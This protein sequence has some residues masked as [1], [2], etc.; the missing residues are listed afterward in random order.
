MECLQ[1]I[2][3]YQR[4][5]ETPYTHFV[6]VII[7]QLSHVQL[8]V[9]PWTVARQAPLLSIISWN[10][11]KFTST[12]AVM[13]S[14]S[15]S[16][17]L[18]SFCLQFFPACTNYPDLTNVNILPYM[19]QISFPLKYLIVQLWLDALHAL[20]FFKYSKRT[21][22]SQTSGFLDFFGGGRGVEL[23][24]LWEPSSLTRDSNQALSHKSAE[25]YPLNS[26]GIP[27]GFFLIH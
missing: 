18:F 12:E 26:Q 23:C 5:Q 2:D 3:K 16:T 7:Q 14:I 24:G 25:S 21:R 1:H 11:L 17:I 15:S 4:I 27:P 6:A 22:H 8:S 10:L 20:F 13:L 9:T 19:L